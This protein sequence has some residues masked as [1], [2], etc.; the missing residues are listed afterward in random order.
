MVN[1][2]RFANQEDVYFRDDNDDDDDDR[3][4]KSF[5]RAGKYTIRYLVIKRSWLFF[6]FSRAFFLFATTRSFEFTYAR[7]KP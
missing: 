6:F 4:L 5:D 7:M 2:A 3:Y 1:D